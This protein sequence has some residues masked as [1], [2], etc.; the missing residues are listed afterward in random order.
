MITEMMTEITLCVVGI[1]TSAVTLLFGALES[2]GR[3]KR[4]SPFH[5][6]HDILIARHAHFLALRQQRLKRLVTNVELELALAL[7]SKPIPLHILFDRTV[8][9]SK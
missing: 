5:Y 3:H 1:I 7:T 4:R 6:E 8:E 2:N 9:L